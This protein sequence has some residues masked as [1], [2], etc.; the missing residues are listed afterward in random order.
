MSALSFK[1][2]KTHGFGPLD[3]DI[4]AGQCVCLSGASGS[5]KSLT[6]RA[7][8]DLDPHEG[9]VALNGEKAMDIN[10]PQWRR[11]VGLLPAE[12][13]WWC[14]TVGEHFQEVDEALLAKVGFKRDVMQ[15]QISRLSTG[16]RQ[17]LSLVR[18]L[19][20]QPRALLLDEPTASLDRENILRI[21]DLINEYRQQHDI[22]VL[23][24]SHDAEQINRVCSRHI[25]IQDGKFVE[26]AP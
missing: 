1:G 24:V 13:R 10:G 26:S 18:L 17:R 3:L 16:E 4:P 23:W 5:G 8:A 14:D 20:N 19:A 22:A 25:K 2:L 9:A 12:S 15:W 11:Q 7:L 21:E 6:L